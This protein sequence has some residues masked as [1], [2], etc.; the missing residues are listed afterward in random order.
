MYKLSVDINNVDEM[1]FFFFHILQ[2]FIHGLFNY[3]YLEG[4]EVGCQF[5]SYKFLLCK[6]PGLKVFNEIKVCW[7]LATVRTS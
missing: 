6:Q 7:C 3:F 1:F 5:E 2:W 4:P